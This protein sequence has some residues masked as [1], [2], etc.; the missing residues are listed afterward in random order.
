MKFAD[1]ELHGAK[2][3]LFRPAVGI[4][5]EAEVRKT[6]EALH[7]GFARILIIYVVGVLPKIAGKQWNFAAH[8]RRICVLRRRDLQVR[9]ALVAYEPAPAAAEKP[10]RAL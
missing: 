5:C 2:P 10:Q 9:A 6:Q 1:I 8:D 7:V 3:L 4:A